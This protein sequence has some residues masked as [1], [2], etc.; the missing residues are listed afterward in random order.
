MNWDFIIST[1]IQTHLPT[2]KLRKI[3]GRINRGEVFFILLLPYLILSDTFQPFF[4]AFLYIAIFA[5]T[6]DRLVLFLKKKFERGR[7]LVKVAGKID[8][9]PDMKYSFPSAHSA[10]SMVV[11]VILVFAFSLS[12]WLFLFTFLAGIGRVLSLHHYPSD[13]IAGWIWGAIL[14]GFGVFFWFFLSKILV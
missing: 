3:L 1:W 8:S 6:N 13:I 2:E 7:P 9:N 11:V 4:L 12:P 5:Y 10:N 14:G